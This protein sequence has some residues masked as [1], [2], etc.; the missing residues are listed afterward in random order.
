[1]S[2]DME[3]ETKTTRLRKRKNSVCVVQ[4]VHY[5]VYAPHWPHPY[6]VEWTYHVLPELL[7]EHA[8]W[9]VRGVLM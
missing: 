7:Y 3:K 8:V 1:M 2:S 5:R 9:L 4:L 6:C